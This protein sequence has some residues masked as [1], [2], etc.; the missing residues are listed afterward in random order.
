MAIRKKQEVLAGIAKKSVKAGNTHFENEGKPEMDL[1]S[2]FGVEN[3]MD[4]YK[5][6]D[7]DEIK[8]PDSIS[9]HTPND[10]GDKP[11]T[12]KAGKKIK[13]AADDDLPNDSH[14][15]STI[16]NEV[17]PADGYLPQDGDANASES[18]VASPNV[19]SN[20][21]EAAADEEEETTEE[22]EDDSADEVEESDD[23]QG[24]DESDLEDFEEEEED[25]DEDPAPEDFDL[26]EDE[27]V[28]SEE[29]EEFEDEMPVGT[30]EAAADDMMDIVDI[31]GIQDNDVEAMVFAALGQRLMV[32]KANRVIAT[33][34]KKQAA[35]ASCDDIYLSSQFHDAAYEEARRQGLRAGLKHM[36]FVMAKVNVGQ[37]QVINKRVEARVK[38]LT[39][40]VRKT[41]DDK[42]KCFAQ[43]LAIASV[44]ITRRFF[45]EEASNELIASLVDQLSRAGVR[46][47]SRIVNAAFAQHGVQY[48]KAIL[49][50]ANKL[51]SMPEEHRAQ[52]ANAL[53]M[54]D[55]NGDF[56]DADATFE[57]ESVSD[58]VDAGA[59]EESFEED[60]YMPET[61]T[62]ALANPGREFKGELLTPRRQRGTPL[63]AHALLTGD[64]P[65]TFF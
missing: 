53:D 7:P 16:D 44:G 34:N 43:C 1:D 23:D 45:K 60:D 36:G 14:N 49:T 20:P 40:A 5:L 26:G 22:V 15:V 42:E 56:V 58:F 21:L 55:E 30:T 10:E 47:G 50:V 6:Y 52:F 28:E 37:S 54:L 41:G 61:V 12:V 9:T 24:E 11:A 29:E 62:A 4:V 3:N 38:T 32:L 48:A 35:K 31:D 39:A 17:D 59:D 27:P 13:A 25:W 2:D 65:L 64:E 51:S 33:M 18:A 19:P 46:N 57:D 8:N 63:S